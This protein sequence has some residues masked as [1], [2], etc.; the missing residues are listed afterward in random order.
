MYK[1]TRSF[2][3]SVNA[4]ATKTG[5]A[6]RSIMDPNVTPAPPHRGLIFAP[7]AHV[8]NLGGGERRPAEWRG[9]MLISHSAPQQIFQRGKWTVPSRTLSPCPSMPTSVRGE[10]SR[11]AR[12]QP[13][14]VPHQQR[15]CSKAG[16]G[17]V[18]AVG[19]THNGRLP[20]DFETGRATCR[21]LTASS[22]PSQ[23]Q[24]ALSRPTLM[25][26]RNAK[27]PEPQ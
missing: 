27:R 14:P 5:T 3:P 8:Q 10:G 4:E 7:R 15:S 20:C 22:V 12:M 25:P 9:Y 1:H 2:R 19:Q 6:K 16:G 13:C 18:G 26:P 23:A 17:P 24:P 21:A 11:S